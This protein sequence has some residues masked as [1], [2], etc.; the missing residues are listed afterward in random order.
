MVVLNRL[1]KAKSTGFLSLIV[2][3]DSNH[4]P[5]WDIDVSSSRM[6]VDEKTKFR[7]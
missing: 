1:K 7:N 4:L 3:V 2:E 5:S 6:L